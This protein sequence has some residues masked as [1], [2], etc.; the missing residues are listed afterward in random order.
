[1]VCDMESIPY[2]IRLILSMLLEFV[3]KNFYFVI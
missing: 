3:K 2:H 1:M